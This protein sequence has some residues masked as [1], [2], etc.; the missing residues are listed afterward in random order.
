MIFVSSEHM[1]LVLLNQGYRTSKHIWVVQPSWNILTGVCVISVNV[2][3]RHV[4]L[5]IIMC[6]FFDICYIIS[7]T[8]AHART[9]T[10]ARTHAHTHTHTCTHTHTHTHHTWL[11][12]SIS[13]Y[14]LLPFMVFL[15]S[16]LLLPR[17]YPLLPYHSTPPSEHTPH[18]QQWV[19]VDS[20]SIQLMSMLH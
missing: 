3:N 12:L 10:H 4:Y 9:C 7:N 16:P 15:G 1:S 2:Q 18:Q 17:Q 13:C 11:T 8:H 6:S 5:N 19:V 14:Q 20:H